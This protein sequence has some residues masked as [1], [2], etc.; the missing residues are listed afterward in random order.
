MRC[1][2][3]MA[4]VMQAQP[5][6][7][8]IPDH[9]G[10]TVQP[11]TGANDED[12]GFHF[13]ELHPQQLQ[14]QQAPVPPDGEFFFDVTTETTT[15]AD[16]RAQPKNV[17][18]RHSV[19]FAAG[20]GAKPKRGATPP[21][22]Q[23][24]QRSS[25]NSSPQSGASPHPAPFR[26]MP[27]SPTEEYPYGWL[28]AGPCVAIPIDYEAISQSSLME[29]G[30]LICEYLGGK[31]NF[32]EVVVA[33]DYATLHTLNPK[34]GRNIYLGLTRHT[35]SSTRAGHQALGP[36]LYIKGIS[37]RHRKGREDVM[38]LLHALMHRF[39]MLAD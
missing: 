12:N 10:S 19:H 7:A 38:A 1:N 17:S 25:W 2:N 8:A 24:P 3:G 15:P 14:G 35:S 13:A 27:V 30:E 11:M 29:A 23:G 36:R 5:S 39:S 22:W 32:S 20:L 9:D 16:A 21:V 4:A 26:R 33:S 28:I 6:D 34:T 37:G 31:I 18:S